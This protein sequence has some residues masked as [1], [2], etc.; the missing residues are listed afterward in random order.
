[1]KSTA[2]LLP[3]LP[4]AGQILIAVVAYDS[5]PFPAMYSIENNGSSFLSPIR[6]WTGGRTPLNW[7][8][9]A[10]TLVFSAPSSSHS[11]RRRE[12]G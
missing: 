10:R 12:M 8:A 4:F 6:T 5:I 9:A 7:E 1:M 2:L 3:T 11:L